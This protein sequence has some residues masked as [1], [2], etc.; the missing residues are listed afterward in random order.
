MLS[1]TCL[2]LM[3]GKMEVELVHWS[4]VQLVLALQ[5]YILTTQHSSL[6]FSA[7]NSPTGSTAEVVGVT[8]AAVMSRIK[9]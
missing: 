9:W 5:L 1:V 6:T 2:H 7:V 8:V 3:V 4:S